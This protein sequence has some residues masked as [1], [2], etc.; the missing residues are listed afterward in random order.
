MRTIKPHYFDDFVC[1]ADKCPDTCCEGWQIVID[2]D[3]LER[4][5]EEKGGYGREL[6]DRID[7]QESSFRQYNGRCACL[8]EN[9][10][11]RLVLEKGEE[12]LC[13]T[14]HRYPR[15]EEEFEGQ[16]EWSLSLSCPIAAEMI[17]L[18]EEPLE[19]VIEEDE[20]PDPLEEEFEDFDFLLFTKLE[21]AREVMIRMAQDRRFSM[22][23]R[24]SRILELGKAMQDALDAEQLYEMDE[25]ISRAAEN[26]EKSNIEV[27]EISTKVHETKEFRKQKECFV[28]LTKLERLRENWQEVLTETEQSLYDSEEEYYK[29]REA[30]EKDFGFAGK[31]YKE[32]EAFLEN[33]F[34]FFLFTY[35]C[36]AVYDD[37]IYS[38][39]AFAVFSV[40][41][42]EEFIMCRWHLADKKIEQSDWVSFAY[43]YA[44]EVE[45]SDENLNMLEEWLMEERPI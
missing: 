43:R 1:V 45:H 30:F 9:N 19:F 21:D 37:W 22:R 13:D 7:W 33:L 8:D 10:L 15:H 2:E 41:Q 17:L 38:K 11:C 5:S 27:K 36:G 12:Y 40:N 35:F 25:I 32:W 29:I 6:A 34:L 18:R 16:R 42:I 28:I 23:E 3:S 20:E 14:C 4:Y 31:F 39:V 26:Y 44:R 24:M